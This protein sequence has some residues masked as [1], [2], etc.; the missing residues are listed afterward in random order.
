MPQ[1][2]AAKRRDLAAGFAGPFGTFAED[3]IHHANFR[4]DLERSLKL[5]MIWRI[6]FT[7]F[8]FAQSGKFT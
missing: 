3:I 4:K 6:T 2:Q 1:E 8:I 5:H 7:D